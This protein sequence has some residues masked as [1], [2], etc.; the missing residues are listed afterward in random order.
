MAKSF[1]ELK[2][3]RK[4]SF[5]ELANKAKTINDK[6]SYSDDRVWSPT[7]GKDGNGYAV[8]RFLPQPAGEDF[9]WVTYYD[10]GFQGPTGLWYIEKSLTSIGKDDPVSK[11]NSS[12]WNSGVEADKAQARTQ[13]RRLHYVSNIYVISDPGNPDNEGKNFLFIYGKK[14]FDKINEVMNPEFEDE[15]PIN[16]FDFWEGANFKLKIR[17]VDGYRNYDKSEF[18]S[19]STLFD[20][21][22]KMEEMY[23]N[24]YPLK[25][26]IDPANYKSYDELEK[27][28]NRVLCLDQDPVETAEK[29]A[30]REEFDNFAETRNEPNLPS[31]EPAFVGTKTESTSTEF[32]D[33]IDD[34]FFKSLAN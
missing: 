34:D 9:S 5:A 16:P 32:D 10:H 30:D 2:K 22:E 6:K 21:D 17:K 4:S 7:V 12:L 11:F 26:Y 24:L 15:T 23:N 31:K 20:D 14:I 13:K 27:K 8:I 19:P 28:M 18:D 3:Q 1:A 29:K 33:D 25:D